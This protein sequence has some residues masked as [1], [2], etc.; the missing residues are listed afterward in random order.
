MVKKLFFFI[1]VKN[2]CP[3]CICVYIYLFISGGYS[4]TCHELRRQRQADPLS[5][6]PACSAQW[7]PGQPGLHNT[8]LFPL[9][10]FFIYVCILCVWAVRSTWELHLNFSHVGF[11]WIWLRS[12][13]VAAITSL[14]YILI[15]KK[16]YLEK[17]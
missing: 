3:S 14:S 13:D 10:C 2:F 16:V 11:G 4:G 12:F 6:G 5:S 7:A 1:A 15:L 9:Q 17:F 8:L